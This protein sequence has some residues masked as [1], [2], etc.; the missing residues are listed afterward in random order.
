MFKRVDMLKVRAVRADQA[1]DEPPQRLIKSLEVGARGGWS[2]WV[3]GG[4]LT[5]HRDGSRI[6][7]GSTFD[8][9]HRP[10]SIMLPRWA[11]LTGDRCRT[12]WPLGD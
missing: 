4:S 9:R 1:Q 12:C 6:V 5:V 11:K 2:W 3:E 7:G 8:P 10:V